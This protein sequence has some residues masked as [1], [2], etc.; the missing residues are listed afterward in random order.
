M[1][2]REFLEDL[3]GRKL[4]EGE[5]KILSPIREEDD[6]SF[7]IDTTKGVWKDFAGEQ[8][9]L[10]DLHV[11]IRGGTR[12][13]AFDAIKA[14]GIDLDKMSSGKGKGRSDESEESEPVDESIVEVLHKRLWETDDALLDVREKWGWTDETLKRFTIGF[15]QRGNRISIP[16]RDADG[17]V[18]NVRFHDPHAASAEMKVINMKGRGRVRLFNVQALTSGAANVVLCEGEKDAVRTTQAI[19]NAGLET[20]WVAVSG[21]GGCETWREEWCALVEGKHVVV[22]YD[23]DAP[24]SQGGAKVGRAILGHAL[25]VKVLRWSDDAPKGHDLSDYFNGGKEF[26]DLLGWIEATEPFTPSTKR[27]RQKKPPD[28]TVYEPHLSEASAAAYLHKKISMRMMVAGKELAPY[29]VPKTVSFDCSMNNGNA[30]AT[31]AMNKVGGLMETSIE[32]T[33]PDIIRMVGV[34]DP[35]RN[36]AIRTKL[37]IDT[38]CRKVKM[39]VEEW[40]NVEEATLVPEIEFSDETREYVSRTAYSL[41]HGIRP[42]MYYVGRGTSIPNPRTQHVVHFFHDMQETTDNIEDFQMSPQVAEELKV[43]QVP[44]G[45]SVRDKMTEIA[46]DLTANVTKIYG[47]EDILIGLD[48]CY[49]SVLA[50][51]FRDKPVGKAWG[52]I[53]LIGD[54]RTGKSEAVEALVRH[55]GI[56]EIATAENTSYA[57]LVGGLRQEAGGRWSLTWGRIPL[58]DRRLLVI[59]EASG[60][61]LDDIG[62]MSGI[63]SNGV[64]ELTKIITQK[65]SARSRLIWIS[66]PRSTRT[67]A[68]H[69]HGIEAVKELIGRPE[70]IARFD[71][72]LS[73]ATQEVPVTVI[74]A[75]EHA[76]I[77]HVHTSELCRKLITWAWSR[78]AD[79]VEFAPGTEER[80]LELATRHSDRYAVQGGV[81]LVEGGNHRIKIAKI[82]VAAAARTFSASDDGERIVVEA[83]HADF[84]AEFLEETYRKPSLDYAGWSEKLLRGATLDPEVEDEVREWI[85]THT[86]WAD[87]WL[88]A[89]YMRPDDFRTV[90]DLEMNEVRSA[91]FKPLAKWRMIVR[92]RSSSYEKS[93]AFITL[94]KE[95]R[96]AMDDARNVALRPSTNGTKPHASGAETDSPADP[97]VAGA[98]AR[99]ASGGASTAGDGDGED[100]PF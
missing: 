55:Y 19:F 71:Y 32:P 3:L 15:Q 92:G 16:V 8:G 35:R 23:A 25:S 97:A 60:L 56:G 34:P 77:D 59:D 86:D 6:P 89:T 83:R 5:Q 50:F 41:S 27:R 58:N 74:N 49:H 24:G 70:D 11:R 46:K 66:N 81:P 10:I 98:S 48:L 61:G 12:K 36:E 31:C 9:G 90:F 99:P 4:E 20:D 80:I 63:R 65:T 2:V 76:S 44:E 21:T 75:Y 29:A 82:A 40:T 100:F 85:R 13:Q 39:E 95:E 64:A 68:Q 72:V 79:Q 53:L 93:T 84:A 26:G 94:L 57:G 33:D 78:S 42:N 28:E 17:V 67:M 96:D 45:K 38:K 18:R 91:I 88:S 87:H 43:F 54:T 30:C 7:S 37:N 1:T 14:A 62:R 69:S 22:A 73:A 52:D 51:A 47:R